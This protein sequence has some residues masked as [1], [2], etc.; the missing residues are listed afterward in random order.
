M[1]SWSWGSNNFQNESNINWLQIEKEVKIQWTVHATI[2]AQ[3]IVIWFQNKRRTIW[4]PTYLLQKFVNWSTNTAPF[5]SGHTKMGNIVGIEDCKH[6]GGKVLVVEGTK[7]K[8]K[9]TQ[10]LIHKLLLDLPRL[11]SL[12]ATDCRIKQVQNLIVR[13]HPSSFFFFW[14]YGILLHLLCCTVE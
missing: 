13:T 11:S 8:K 3:C 6:N 10:A 14:K 2:I 1:L 12:R 7:L 4:D 5:S 9:D